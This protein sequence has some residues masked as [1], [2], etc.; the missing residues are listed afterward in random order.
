MK[1]NNIK[2]AEEWLEKAESDLSFAKASFDEFSNFYSQMCILCHDSVEKYLKAYIISL[3]IKPEHI[4]DLLKLL[5]TCKDKEKEFEDYLEKCR[6]LNRYYTPLK[7]PSHYPML[8]K[9]QAKEAIDIAEEIGKF[10]NNLI[11]YT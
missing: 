3:G 9:E 7:Y 6:I 11:F 10:V 4:H 5:N 1:K 8:T 2:I